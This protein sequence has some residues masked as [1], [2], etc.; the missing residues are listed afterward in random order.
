MPDPESLV[1]KLQGDFHVKTKAFLFL[2]VARSLL[3]QRQVL[4]YFNLKGGLRS[5]FSLAVT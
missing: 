5:F 3:V 4:I 1:Q 2:A